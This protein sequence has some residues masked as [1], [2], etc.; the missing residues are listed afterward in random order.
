MQD[1]GKQG[2]RYYLINIV[3]LKPAG[4]KKLSEVRGLA[5]SDYQDYLEKEW[6]KELRGK[7]EVKISD[8]ELNKLIQK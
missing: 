4:T 2:D 7:Y 1:I 6:L 5:I 3:S 8:S